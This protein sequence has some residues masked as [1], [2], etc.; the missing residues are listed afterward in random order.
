M[1]SPI[2]LKKSEF[3]YSVL[4]ME[5]IYAITTPSLNHSYTVYCKTWAR[6]LVLQQKRNTRLKPKLCHDLRHQPSL[7]IFMMCHVTPTSMHHPTTTTSASPPVSSV[8]TYIREL[9]I[10]QEA[11]HQ[12]TIWVN[13]CTNWLTN[14]QSDRLHSRVKK[15]TGFLPTLLSCVHFCV[16]L[17]HPPP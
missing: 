2:K 10:P 1:L 9:R 5:W 4:T 14:V 13:E 3:I 15:T 11:L 7:I 6:L 16:S 12:W 8:L 17:L